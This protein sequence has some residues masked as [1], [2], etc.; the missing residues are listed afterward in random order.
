MEQSATDAERA[1]R[2]GMGTIRVGGTV[3][4]PHVIRIILGAIR[5]EC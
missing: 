2:G 4:L 1:L 5:H 3:K